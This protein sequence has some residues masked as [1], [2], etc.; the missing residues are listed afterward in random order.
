MINDWPMI[1]VRWDPYVGWTATYHGELRQKLPA[2]Y[3]ARGE[4]PYHIP[5]HFSPQEVLQHVRRD[6]PGVDVI[7]TRGVVERNNF[8]LWHRPERRQIHR[9]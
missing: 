6:H 4:T 8:V 3:R 5:R 1:T 9:S 7:M 2:Q